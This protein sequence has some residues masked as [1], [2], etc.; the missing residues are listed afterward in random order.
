M[1]GPWGI[2]FSV[3]FSFILDLLLGDPEWMPHPVVLMGKCISRIEKKLRLAFPETSAGQRHAGM[4]LAALLPVFTFLVSAGAIILLQKIYAP[5][6]F[7]LNVFWGWQAL[8]MRDLRK[9]SMNVYAA[10]TGARD[11]SGQERKR[12]ERIDECAADTTDEA[13]PDSLYKARK[14]V[15]RIV[16]RDTMNLS[17]EG[18]T[19]A[20][21]ETVA[22]NFSD[23]VIA[24]MIYLAIGGAP[25]A[26]CYKAI[27]T[28]DSMI[29]YK[30]EKYLDFGRAAARLDDAVNYIP[31]R[32]SALL[33]IAA[34]WIC[35]QNPGNAH[36]IWRRDRRNHASPNS[37]QTEAAMAGALEIQLGGPAWYFGEYYD[38]PTI[39]DPLKPPVPEDIRTANRM[40]YCGG[41]LGLILLCGITMVVCFGLMQ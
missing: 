32:L 25:L 5:A 24:P 17:A 30:N 40:M 10:L 18:V 7:L 8:A 28:M 37:A 14:A 13:V 34:A 33:L 11:G 27:N 3:V 21:V 22:E 31:S 12:D 26:L 19:K 9:E 35:R 38:K 41:F 1:I 36:R 39:G 15:A 2:I 4:I 20:C 16:G 23:G 6:A 29:G